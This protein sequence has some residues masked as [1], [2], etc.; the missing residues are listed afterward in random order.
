MILVLA[1]KNQGKIREIENT[2][3]IPSLTYKSLNDFTG[4]PEIVEDGSSFL[5]NAFKKARTISKA[6]NLA[7]MADDSGLVVDFLHGAPGIYSAR[8]AG[9]QSTDPQNNEKLLGLLTGVP[10]TKRTARFVCVLVLYLPTGAWFQTEGTCEGRIALAPEGDQGFGYDPVFYLAEFQKTMA[11][12]P[13]ETK[14][15]ISH[16]SKALENMRPHLQALLK[17]SV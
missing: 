5:E 12:L 8:F 7:V 17:G 10:E 11:G 2:L 1:S 14:N 16:R 4:L 6:L 13:L 9:D 15:Q 3:V